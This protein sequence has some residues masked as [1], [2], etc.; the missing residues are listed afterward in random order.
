MRALLVPPSWA[1]I[2]G[3]PGGQTYLRGR[4]AQLQRTRPAHSSGVPWAAPRLPPPLPVAEPPSPT[5]GRLQSCHGHRACWAGMAAHHSSR[6][7][8]GGVAARLPRGHLRLAWREGE[9]TGWAM[10]P[11]V[12][13][14]HGGVRAGASQTGERGPQAAQR[15]GQAGGAPHFSRP[16][17]GRFQV[18]FPRARR[19]RGPPFRTC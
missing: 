11:K 8:H 7:D 3:W 18:T 2:H 16:V 19:W 6:R 15:Q 5:L 4:A 12:Q 1:C 10:R 17:C 13:A 9:G 14:C